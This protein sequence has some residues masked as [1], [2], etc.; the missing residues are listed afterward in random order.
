[1]VTIGLWFMHNVLSA[2]LNVAKE[3]QHWSSTIVV[4]I[5]EF[6]EEAEAIQKARK[7]IRVHGPQELVGM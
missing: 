6:I 5:K 7:K 3:I 1:M 2:Y 4:I